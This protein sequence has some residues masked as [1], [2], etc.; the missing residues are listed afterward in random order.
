MTDHNYIDCTLIA[1][2]ISQNVGRVGIVDDMHPIFS[3]ESKYPLRFTMIANSLGV[4]ADFGILFRFRDI[5]LLG[6]TYTFQSDGNSIK[7]TFEC[8]HSYSHSLNIYKDDIF[9]GKLTISQS[10]SNGNGFYMFISSG[11][12][13]V[14]YAN[15]NGLKSALTSSSSSSNSSSSTSSSS[16]SSSSTSNPSSSASSSP[17]STNTLNK[18]GICIQI[19]ITMI[20]YLNLI[21]MPYKQIQSIRHQQPFYFQQHHHRQLLSV[22]IYIHQLLYEMNYN[23]ICNLAIDS[24]TSSVITPIKHSD[25]NIFDYTIYIILILILCIIAVLC[26]FLIY[27]FKKTHNTLTA[28]KSKGHTFQS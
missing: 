25:V 1:T 2:S 8:E 6:Y 19:L 9:H 13:I 5:G 24:S 28:E 22:C 16:T 15:F 21:L 12:M 27:W 14:N 18:L 17:T 3:D 23:M 10:C 7:V 26:C 4:T 20:S 11:S